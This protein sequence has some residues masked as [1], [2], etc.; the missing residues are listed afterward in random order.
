MVR[1]YLP[2]RSYAQKPISVWRVKL[3]RRWHG[4]DYCSGLTWDDVKAD[5]NLDNKRRLLIQEAAKQL[6]DDR[7]IA[8]DRQTGS[9]TITDLGR[10]AAK[11]YI[12]YKSIETFNK[13]MRPKMSEADVLVMICKSS[14]VRVASKSSVHVIDSYG[15]QV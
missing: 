15:L 14:E 4:A 7:M 3:L 10:I 6:N 11:Y 13:L 1:L 9:L 2:V 8:F 5:P 12:R